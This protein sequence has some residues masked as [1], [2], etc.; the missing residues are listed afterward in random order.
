M[1]RLR[2]QLNKKRTSLLKS[3][4]ILKVSPKMRNLGILRAKTL[5]KEK[6]DMILTQIQTPFQV[7]KIHKNN[8]RKDLVETLILIR[9]NHHLKKQKCREVCTLWNKFRN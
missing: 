8:H 4:T 6:E 3:K 7:A 1:N 9:N 2:N 5:A